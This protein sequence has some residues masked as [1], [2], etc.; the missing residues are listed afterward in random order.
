MERRKQP[1]NLNLFSIHFPIAAVVSILHRM[2]GVILFLAI[3]VLLYCLQ[4]S[5]ENAQG[6]EQIR[7]W[8]HTWL[9]EFILFLLLW[10]LLHHLFAGIRFLLLD[11]DVGLSRRSSQ[12][13]AAL[14]V[15]LSLVLLF[16][17]ILFI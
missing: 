11:I 7:T 4:L 14:V 1:V 16:S 12:L 6:Y 17:F 8:A 9:F 10:A 15:I 5:I 3:P 13:T 2:S